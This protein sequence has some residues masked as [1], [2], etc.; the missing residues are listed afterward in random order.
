MEFDDAIGGTRWTGRPPLLT[1]SGLVR[2]A[3][4]QAL[5]GHRSEAR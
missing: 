1:D 2:L 5:L 3:V 4:A